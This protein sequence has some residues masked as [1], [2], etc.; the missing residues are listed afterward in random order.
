[1]SNGYKSTLTR[2]QL[3]YNILYQKDKNP[4]EPLRDII[5]KVLKMAECEKS[6][7]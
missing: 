2:E 4:A 1:M 5:E 6:S 7:N 3:I